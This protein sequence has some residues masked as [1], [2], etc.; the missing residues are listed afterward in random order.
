V[1]LSE[2]GYSIVGDIKYSKKDDVLKGKG[3]FLSANQLEF[4]HP[5]NKDRIIVAIDT[6]SKFKNLC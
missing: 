5:I 2:A 6:P 3:I 4:I 1:H